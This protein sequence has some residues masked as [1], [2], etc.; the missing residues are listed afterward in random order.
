MWGKLLTH[1]P[2]QLPAPNFYANGPKL[3]VLAESLFP[4]HPGQ[5]SNMLVWQCILGGNV[6][7]PLCG[8]SGSWMSF[9]VSSSGVMHRT[10]FLTGNRKFLANKKSVPSG[11]P[12]SPCLNARPPRDS[13][14][15]PP[16]DGTAGPTSNHPA[17]LVMSWQ[18]LFILDF[19]P[20]RG[21][22][23]RC[24]DSRMGVQAHFTSATTLDH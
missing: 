14:P 7:R 6:C 23:N 13:R 24:F 15:R 18:M 11:M 8:A 22:R 2:T 16:R 20:V 19:L 21:G 12:P 3:G 5:T 4:H 10:S 1:T 9:Y 17:C